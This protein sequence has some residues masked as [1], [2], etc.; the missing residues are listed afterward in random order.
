L[1]DTPQ[2]HTVAYQ[3]DRRRVSIR[4]SRA[5]CREKRAGGISGRPIERREETPAQVRPPQL[6]ASFIVRRDAASARRALTHDNSALSLISNVENVGRRLKTFHA[7]LCRS[8]H[9]RFRE[10]PKEAQNKRI[11]VAQLSGIGWLGC[12]QTPSVLEIHRSTTCASFTLSP[13]SVATDCGLSYKHCST[14]WQ[15]IRTQSYSS[16]RTA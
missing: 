6:V 8:I 11:V 12:P 2:E 16:G 10:L 3:G 4:P 9:V 7:F 15:L 5:I 14:G 13:P 1:G